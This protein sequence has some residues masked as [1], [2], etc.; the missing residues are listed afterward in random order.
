MVK[1]IVR[2]T[3]EKN[4]LIEKGDVIILGLSGGPDSVCLFDILLE[5]ST[6][7]DFQIHGAHVN[8]MFR[9]GAAEEDQVYVENLC[10]ANGVCSWSKIVDC[11][12]LSEDQGISSEEAGREARYSFFAEVA[13]SLVFEGVEKAKIKIAIAQNLNDQVETV[14]FRILRGTGIDGIAGIEY[15]RTNKY[16]NTVIRP[17]L[18]VKKADILKYCVDNG[19]NPKF[20]HTNEEPIYARNKIRLEL[21]PMLEREYNSNLT[22]VISRMSDVAKNDKD[23]IWQEAVKLYEKALVRKEE[24]EVWLDQEMLA[25]MHT[26]VRHRVIAKAFG[27]IGLYS[28]ITNAHYKQADY[29]VSNNETPQQTDLPK[30]YVIRSSYGNIICGKKD[31]KRDKKVFPKFIINTVDIEQYES[32]PGRAA[33]D[34]DAMQ[35]E[36]GRSEIKDIISI[37]NREAGDYIYLKGVN[38]RKK[39]QDLF[40]DMK[41]PAYKRDDVVLVTIGHEVLWIVNEEYKGRY[42]CNYPL[43]D[44]T[45]R[46]ITVEKS[47]LM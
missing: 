11:Q 19:L 39:L 29:I 8:H 3:I 24:N 23:F 25:D 16:G 5:L 7:M 21:I 40:V 27:E 18:D 9:P 45:K 17:L 32:K 41:I 35:E 47:S 14:L 44:N 1:E 46:V 34:L 6:E 12:Q 26:A 28:D 15:K 10:E 30:G 43:K 31:E 36:F 42:S 22:E 37:R 38:G 4:N 20:D 13:D 2:K 33:F